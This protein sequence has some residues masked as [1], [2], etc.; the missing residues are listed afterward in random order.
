MW[1]CWT[2]GLLFRSSSCSQYYLPGMRSALHHA[3]F[4][5]SLQKKNLY[6]PYW[7]V[8]VV[9]LCSRWANKLFKSNSFLVSHAPLFFLFLFPFVRSYEKNKNEKPKT[10][11]RFTS[12]FKFRVVKVSIVVIFGKRIKPT[13]S[14]CFLGNANGPL[15]VCVCVCVC[16]YKP[17]N[18]YFRY[19]RRMVSCILL[20]MRIIA[21]KNI[22]G[23]S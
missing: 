17:F 20:C 18:I 1:T 4:Q 23:C 16:S 13:S 6:D 14:R 5:V 8:N 3:C 10:C 19:M 2:R 21:I 11:F 12:V 7:M 15:C 22:V 9:F